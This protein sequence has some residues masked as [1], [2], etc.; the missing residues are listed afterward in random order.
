MRPVF[1]AVAVWLAAAPAWAAPSP[2]APPPVPPKV[3][4][5]AGYAEPEIGPA[6]CRI[7]NAGE[8]QCAVPAMTAGVYLVQAVGTS[9]AQAADAVQQ[10]TVVA[11]DQSCTSTRS[12]D[13]K[14]PWAVGA[15]RSLLSGC[16]FTIVTDAPL[17][18]TVVYLDTKAAKDPKGPLVSVTRE[19]WTGV[20]NALPISV[21]QP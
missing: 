8:T 18:I 17:A 6:A 16:V 4:L 12:P 2:A 10:L 21:K 1:I 20:L 9:T 19:P 7:V 13:P 11:G 14:T 15:K 3:F 5:Q